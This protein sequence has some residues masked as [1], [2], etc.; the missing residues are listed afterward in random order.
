MFT[1]K[2]ILKSLYCNYSEFFHDQITA[3]SNYIIVV[4]FLSRR[5]KKKFHQ[6][7]FFHLYE[8]NRIALLRSFIL[9]NIKIGLVTKWQHS[10]QI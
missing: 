5:M 10:W 4:L 9:S 3:K 2:K 7:F 1:D 6:D 8:R